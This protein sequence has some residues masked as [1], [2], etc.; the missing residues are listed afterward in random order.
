[1]SQSSRHFAQ[2]HDVVASSPIREQVAHLAQHYCEPEP[3]LL[4]TRLCQM[5]TRAR[6]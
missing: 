1:M 2:S 6:R 3:I 5:G 4:C